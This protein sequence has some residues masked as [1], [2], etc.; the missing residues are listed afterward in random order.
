MEFKRLLAC[1]DKFL[2][3]LSLF[4]IT[5]LRSITKAE[6]DKRSAELR[7]G[8]TVVKPEIIDTFEEKKY[9]ADCIISGRKGGDSIFSPK[10]TKNEKNISVILA[11][12]LFQ[13][14]LC[15]LEMLLLGAFEMH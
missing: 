3:F 15:F 7:N 14:I 10:K 12:I 6:E 2:F 11:G 4:L 1:F 13:S 9:L 8:A 5:I